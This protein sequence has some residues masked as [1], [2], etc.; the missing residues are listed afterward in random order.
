VIACRIF[1]DALRGRCWRT[2]LPFRGW[3]HQT[4]E[5][6]A[7][8]PYLR[9]LSASLP[10][11]GRDAWTNFELQRPIFG[12]ASSARGPLFTRYND[13]TSPGAR[14]G[15]MYDGDGRMQW[16]YDMA[17]PRW[18]S[19]ES[20][21]IVRKGLHN[22]QSPPTAEIG[23]IAPANLGLSIWRWECP[24]YPRNWPSSRWAL[25]KLMGV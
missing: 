15:G 8:G 6:L 21:P 17:N 12:Q 16:K 3:M 19:R 7:T 10:S 2:S 4:T 5:G 25:A 22:K 23:G 13:S 24:S 18:D 14:F 20:F 9:V 11:F 1:R